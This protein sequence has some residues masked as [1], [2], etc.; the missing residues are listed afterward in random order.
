LA[1]EKKA[2]MR[3]T[4]RMLCEEYERI[5]EMNVKTDKIS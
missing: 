2:A 1:E 5:M 4:V 3:A